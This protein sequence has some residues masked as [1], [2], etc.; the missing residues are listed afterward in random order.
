MQGLLPFYSFVCLLAYYFTTISAS[1]GV[2]PR[3]SQE[4]FRIIALN[5]CE[6][7]TEN[8]SS[9]REKI[10]NKTLFILR[11]VKANIHW[12]VCA[13]QQTKGFTCLN[14][15]SVWSGHHYSAYFVDKEAELGRDSWIFSSSLN[16]ERG[17]L[18]LPPV[19]G[20]WQSSLSCWTLD[21]SYWL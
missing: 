7:S 13:R 21:R 17:G 8:L 12:V 15:L 20:F 10:S 2:P 3:K 16:L 1:P 11:T 19:K 6:V 18:G 4:R 14:S 5:V 9:N